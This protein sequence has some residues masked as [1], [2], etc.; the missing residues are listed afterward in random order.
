MASLAA[1]HARRRSSGDAAVTSMGAPGH[2]TSWARLARFAPLDNLST[3]AAV[4]VRAS[5]MHTWSPPH[6]A[7][8]ACP[9]GLPRRLQ[10]LTGQGFSRLLPHLVV[11]AL[12]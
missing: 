3:S 1:E 6:A 11:G 2:R 4:A 7:C 10:G 5:A 9:C 12:A 8:C